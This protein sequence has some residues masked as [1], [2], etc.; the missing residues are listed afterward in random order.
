MPKGAHKV[1]GG[2]SSSS[3]V[4]YLKTPPPQNWLGVGAAAATSTLTYMAYYIYVDTLNCFFLAFFLLNTPLDKQTS[5][6]VSVCNLGKSP[7]VS[8]SI[9]Q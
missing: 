5:A 8:F 6:Y 1:E 7:S 9:T 4:R 2:G 3:S